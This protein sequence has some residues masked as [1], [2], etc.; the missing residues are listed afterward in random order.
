MH[1]MKTH[2]VRAIACLAGA[3]SLVSCGHF[4]D[5]DTTRRP[6]PGPEAIGKHWV[7]DERLRGVMAEL[8][9]QSA[10]W[11]A[12]LPDDPEVRPP[13]DADQAFRDAARLADGLARGARDIPRAVAD[14]EMSPETRRGFNAEASRLRSQALQLKEAARGRKVERMQRLLDG[15]SSSCISC[16]S[17]YRDFT[18]EIGTTRAA[19]E[20]LVPQGRFTEAAGA[21]NL[22]H[23]HCGTNH[24]SGAFD[25]SDDGRIV[26]GTSAPD[27][28]V[29]SL[30]YQAF[31]WTEGGGM[32]GPT[33]LP[34]G[35]DYSTATT[36]SADGLIVAG[37]GNGPTDPA[38]FWWT[39]AAR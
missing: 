29:G 30:G 2:L 26:V 15:I 14:R 6:G 13:A 5:S 23:L 39:S 20:S 25:V 17:Q 36:V 11:P 27:G 16:H 4:K 22:R 18:G 34:R 21:L 28:S 7:Q 19:A 3:T 1:K 8:S 31:R 35:I 9:R 10:N 33:D 24:F 32:A 12:G 37:W 38:Y